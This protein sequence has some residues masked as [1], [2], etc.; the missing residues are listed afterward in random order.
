MHPDLAIDDQ[1]RKLDEEF[2]QTKQTG[3]T[4]VLRLLPSQ[5]RVTGVTENLQGKVAPPALRSKSNGDNYATIR[6]R[7]AVR[8]RDDRSFH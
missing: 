2:E 8:K 3:N 5:V 1:E 7:H 4:R 6:Q